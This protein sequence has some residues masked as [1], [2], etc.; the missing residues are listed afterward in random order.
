MSSSSGGIEG[1]KSS[2]GPSLTGDYK[3]IA[4]N[5]KD[6]KRFMSQPHIK[7]Q[8][9]ISGGDVYWLDDKNGRVIFLPGGDID[10]VLCVD[11]HPPNMPGK[12]FHGKD[13]HLAARTFMIA[14][15]VIGP[16]A[17]KR[18][19]DGGYAFHS[20]VVHGKEKY[21]R[22]YVSGYEKDATGEPKFVTRGV[23]NGLV[24]EEGDH[25]IFERI[26]KLYDSKF[27]SDKA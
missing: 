12:K 24:I 20:I 27:E 4:S 6:L 11:L 9:K 18:S 2:G 22:A 26:E 23:D 16:A 10:K 13:L 19:K 8:S 15:D 7:A 17:Q 3:Y 14:F 25:K 5:T 21:I 1:S